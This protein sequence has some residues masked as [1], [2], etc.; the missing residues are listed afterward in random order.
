MSLE[1]TT[2]CFWVHCFPKSP[3]YRRVKSGRWPAAESKL[4]PC[5][6]ASC[7]AI[8]MS[9]SEHLALAKI[10]RDCLFFR[11]RKLSLSHLTSIFHAERTQMT[12]VVTVPIAKLIHFKQYLRRSILCI[13]RGHFNYPSQLSSDWKSMEMAAASHNACEH[14]CG[15]YMTSFFRRP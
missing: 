7:F 1:L 5:S 9:L 12:T 3:I 8:S 6:W 13:E 2:N 15:N 4:L 11:L 14:V 10:L